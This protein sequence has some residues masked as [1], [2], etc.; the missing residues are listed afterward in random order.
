MSTIEPNQQAATNTHNEVAKAI[1]DFMT[2]CGLGDAHVNA[3]HLFLAFE[4]AYRP[5]P[6]FWRDFDMPA[7]VEAI[8]E[9]FPDWRSAVQKP[10]WSADDVL[11]EVQEILH[12]N[13]F[14]EANAEMMLGVAE[15]ARPTEWQAA[16][17]W[18]CEE[19]RKRK[20]GAELRFAERLGKR[21][22]EGALQELH[23]LE[24]IANGV[25]FERIGTSVA[26]TWRNRVLAE[27]QTD[28]CNA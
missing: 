16:A 27:R 7:L 9:R 8:S 28:G 23:C 15:E 4:F 19:L 18:I 17:D 21:C 24:C 5:L 26:R 11:R 13:A 14:D 12:S 3:G 20:L 10:N 22:G 2:D 6:R 25:E 1:I